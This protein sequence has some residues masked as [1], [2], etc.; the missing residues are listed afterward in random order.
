[1]RRCKIK[2][3]RDRS[4]G[5]LKMCTTMTMGIY[6]HRWPVF[7]L[8]PIYVV[9]QSLWL[10]PSWAVEKSNFAA[11]DGCCSL[12]IA[13]NHLILFESVRC[14]STFF[15][16]YLYVFSIKPSCFHPCFTMVPPWRFRWRATL[17]Q[18]CARAAK[19]WSTPADLARLE[20]RWAMVSHG[21][22][23]KG[24]RYRPVHLIK[25]C[26]PLVN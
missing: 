22:W 10:D 7:Q 19:Y 4:S 8:Q 17:A 6:G 13:Q 5:T 11:C 1:M 2:C 3:T 23:M 9:Q 21:S 12:L 25:K 18:A 20:P 16:H 15:H 26:Y 14:F 24:T